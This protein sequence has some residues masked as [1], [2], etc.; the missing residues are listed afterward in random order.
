ML[1]YELEYNNR[2][3]VP[4]H[5]EINARWQ[6]ASAAYRAA[7]RVDLDQTYG[8]GDRHRFDLFLAGKADAPLVVY[9]HGGYWQRGDRS[10]YA[11]LAQVLNARGLDVALPSYALCPAV[12]VMDIVSEL[13][14]FLVAL[15]RKTGKHALLTGHSAGGHL[16]AAMLA[17]DWCRVAGAHRS[18]AQGHCRQRCIRPGAP[19][20]H[21]PQRCPGPR[22]AGR[23]CGKPA[24]LAAAARSCAGG[25]GW[26]RREWRIPAP[27]PRDHNALAERRRQLPVSGGARGKS[28]HGPRRAGEP[29]QRPLH[30]THGVRP[31]LERGCRAFAPAMTLGRPV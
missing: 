17:T 26:W 29:R 31:R 15:W 21:Q 12:S 22:R 20:W 30:Q 27:K 19:C 8:P 28:F 9:I 7:A 3:R 5:V 18:G 25:R 24:V 4:E 10:D 11:F 14:S 2:R 1:D 23:A 13:R 6:T 16:T